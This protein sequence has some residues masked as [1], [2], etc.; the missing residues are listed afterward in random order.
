VVKGS[1]PLANYLWTHPAA[2][3]S[4][5]ERTALADGLAA[6]AGLSP[7]TPGAGGD[8]DHEGEEHEENE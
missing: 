6:T 4:D 3:L 7:T 5:A 2:R 8:S 1:M